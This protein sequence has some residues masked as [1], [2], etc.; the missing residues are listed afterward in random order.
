M[1]TRDDEWTVRGRQMAAAAGFWCEDI[2]EQ[3]PGRRTEILNGQVVLFTTRTARS[4]RGL[5]TALAVQI[6][7][8][9]CHQ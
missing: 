6:S 1:L 9:W 7:N 4:P 3:M 8:A 2:A 5:F